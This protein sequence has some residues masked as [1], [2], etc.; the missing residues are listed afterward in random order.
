M[1]TLLVATAVLLVFMATRLFTNDAIS[2]V[3]NTGHDVAAQLADQTHEYFNLLVNSLTTMTEIQNQNLSPAAKA[4]ELAQLFKRNDEILAVATWTKDGQIPQYSNFKDNDSKYKDYMNSLKPSDRAWKGELD[5]R[6]VT[7]NGEGRLALSFPLYIDA[8]KNVTT[9]TVGLLT[10]AEF[11]KIYGKE[12]FVTSYLVDRDGNVLAHPKESLVNSGANLKDVAIVKEM[13]QSTSNNGV[14][15]FTYLDGKEYLGAFRLVGVAGVGVVSQVLKDVALASAQKVVKESVHTAG[16]ILFLTFGIAYFF[17]STLTKPIKILVLLTD[18]IRR[19]NFKI[20]VKPKG[21]DEITQLTKSFGQ[22][23][24]GLAERDKLKETFNKFHSKEI[25]DAILNGEIKLG[26]NRQ[27]ATVFFS[28]IRNF[29]SMSEEM[30]AEQ[31]VEML[32]EYMTAMVAEIQ[33]HHGVVDKYVG[34]AIMAVWGVP[35]AKTG[36]A[37]NA[38]SACLAMREKLSTFNEGRLA[39]GKK[40]IKIGMGMHSGELIAGNIGSTEKMEYTVI[41]DTVNTA[42]RIES[43]TKEFGTDLLISEEVFNQVKE[44]IIVEPVTAH[45]KG[46]AKGLTAYKVKGYY[47]QAGK[48]VII[49]T[50]YS[51]YESGHSDK[52][53]HEKAS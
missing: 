34:D 53:V 30:E 11:V 44:K 48:A 28:D 13:L 37:W 31:V 32:N 2:F 8:Q 42:S 20:Q 45:V 18:E 1:V 22:M 29:T 40:P 3:Y 46:K 10:Q 9:A 38:V 35:V 5:L 49:E 52:V 47:D 19:G 4:N 33:S 51:T 23:A 14:K 39:V 12:S 41:G 36:D 27:V 21:H 50:P 7:V 25:A 17:S 15:P 16:I 43:L 26:G 6:R 24:V